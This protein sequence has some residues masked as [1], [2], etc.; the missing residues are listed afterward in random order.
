M[1]QEKN[2]I[3]GII[4]G[5]IGGLIA[6][7]PWILMYVYGGMI[8]SILA[9]VVAFGVLKGYQLAKGK[10]DTKLPII[11]ITISVLSITVATFLIIPALLM[12]KENIAVNIDNFQYLFE[13]KEFVSALIGDYIISL[14]FTFLGISG[15]V[16]NVKKQLSEGKTE[17]IKISAEDSINNINNNKENIE[18]FRGAFLKYD[19]MSKEKAI[20]KEMILQEIKREDAKSLFSNLRM[21]QIIAKYKGKYYFKEKY[22]NSTLKRFLKIYFLTLLII[23]V[24]VIVVLAIA[25]S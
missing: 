3:T 2:Y 15:V 18:L 19:A 10:I 14:L 1:E 12:A 11:I 9:I 23:L 13:N 4:G 6:T 22:A 24:F 7:I 16:K 20:E 17:N 5:I 8:L 25:L 21:Q